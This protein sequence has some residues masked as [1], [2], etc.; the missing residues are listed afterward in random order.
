MYNI[1]YQ[2]SGLTDY[3]DAALHWLEVSLNMARH[4]DGIAGYKTWHLEEYGGWKSMPGLLDGTAGI[5]LSLL[6]FVSEREPGW[7][8]SLLII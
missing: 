4:T 3:R 2:Q 7:A 6:S 1:F 8:R 5:L